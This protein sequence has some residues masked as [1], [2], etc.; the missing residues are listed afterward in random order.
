MTHLHISVS[1]ITRGTLA[2]THELKNEAR[3]AK[4]EG[5]RE[6]EIS[7]FCFLRMPELRKLIFWIFCIWI[8]LVP[9][10]RDPFGQRRG[11][12]GTRLDQKAMK[13]TTCEPVCA[14]F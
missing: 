8:N 2:L 1:A 11:S 4:K 13:F 5:K 10:G 6:S 14:K 3:K 9:I 12:L 7:K